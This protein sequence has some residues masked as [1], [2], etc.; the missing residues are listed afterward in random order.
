MRDTPSESLN[1]VGTSP[2][3]IEA[4]EKVTGRTVYLP[5]FDVPGMTHAK[6]LRS[7]LPHARLV[8][9]DAS[10][11]NALD[12]VIC[13]L[14]R[15]EL[16]A[17]PRV[18]TMYGYVFRDSPLVAL[19]RVRYQ[20]DIVAVVVAEDLQAAEEALELID[21]EY[22][23]L[24]YVL[25]A[26]QAMEPGAPLVHDEMLPIAPELHPVD[27]TNIC[28][29]TTLETGDMEK[30]FAEAD[31]IFE[32][33]YEA[34]PVQHCAL[35]LH[36]VIADVRDDDMTVWTNCQAPFPLKTELERIF[37]R[38]ARVI[39][40]YVG[41]GFGSKSRDR[42]EAVVAAA[43]NLARRP[44]RLVLTQEETFLGGYI[45]PAFKCWI[46]TGVKRD[47]TIV[48]RQYRFITDVGG[49]AIT[50]A[51]SANNTVKVATGPYRI[52][53]VSVECL[54]V[55][56]NKPPS[57]PYRGLPTTQHTMAY[58]SQLD[59][60]ARE[61]G[62]SPVEIRMRNLLVE[63]DV[64]VT[65]DLIRSSHAKECLAQTVD[66]LG[67][68]PPP[69]APGVLRGRGFSS[70]IKYTLTPPRSSVESKAEVALGAD[71]VYEVRVATVNIGQGSDTTMAQIAAE[72]LGA[73]LANVRVVHSDTGL[74]P[75]DTSTTASRSTFHMG[76]AV[77]DAA[78]KLRAEIID[79][80]SAL[81][82]EEKEAL[83]LDGSGARV[84]DAPERR[85]SL[86]ELVGAQG[87]PLSM[88]GEC[89]VGGTYVDTEGR[90]YPISSTFW[91]FASAGADVEVSTETGEVRLTKVSSAVNVG[92]AINPVSVH[93]Q[94]EGGLG[95]ELGPTL[96]ERLVW[97]DTGQLLTSS[98]LDYPLP[99]MSTMPEYATA[100]V[101]PHFKGG[102]YGAKGM[103]EVGSVVLPAAVLNAVYD[104]TGVL[105]HS[106]PLDP[107]TVLRAL[108]AVAG[109]APGEPQ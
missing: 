39:V 41:G 81:L 91:T 5:D 77:L 12:G 75:S 33:I 57:A 59:R 29:R 24:P 31:S 84:A 79:V 2:S 82:E 71:G 47:G 65:G 64:H 56:T 38:P 44:V 85:I 105:F 55:Y 70:T 20:G 15:E 34:P 63:G 48:A 26:E 32:D 97:D 90:S 46:K 3:T 49:Y 95:M 108:V 103:G 66:A 13:V 86:A 50:G 94:I 102:P 100:L 16:L 104:A 78:T 89:E 40:S 11:A 58:E 93:R 98:L 17:D 18:E 73:T 109:E 101:E 25:D 60:I 27:G 67:E 106:V 36:A 96:F 80:S 28:H 99:T 37:K 69:P 74:V 23:E 88:F 107:E 62:I 92:K 83:V 72:A 19:D 7:P 51:R 45:R 61:L 53:N 76:N 87:G 14:T 22:E 4:T 1:V 43:S 42:I 9:I 30:G 8:S 52:P 21:V 54:A 35:E 10:R 68:R 6:V